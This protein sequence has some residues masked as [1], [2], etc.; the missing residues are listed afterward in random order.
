MYIKNIVMGFYQTGVV[1]HGFRATSRQVDT[2]DLEP[3]PAHIIAHVRVAFFLSHYAQCA[4]S[5]KRFPHIQ[6][7]H[8]KWIYLLP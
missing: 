5:P 6:I 3:R 7:F 1:V 2:K 4:E 8:I